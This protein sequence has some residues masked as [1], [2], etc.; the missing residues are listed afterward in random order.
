MASKPSRP[1][2][3][4]GDEARRHAAVDE[5]TFATALL[6]FRMRRAAE[7]VLGDGAQSSGRRSILKTLVA[8]GAQ[9]VPQM[10]R[11]RA[12]SRQHIQKL[13]NGLLDDDLVELLHNPAHKRSRLVAVT[14][15][16]RR[17]AAATARREER[18]LLEVSRGI[19]LAD[20]RTATRVLQTLEGAF[21]SQC[22]SENGSAGRVPSEGAD[23][24]RR[25]RRGSPPA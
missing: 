6:F 9:T 25:E 19:P 7:E 1:R 10:A 8:G 21:E 3:P 12:V 14:G 16:G 20:I 5:L 15:K 11:F 2:Q 23:P 22:R 4:A 24:G 13:V 18:I 17:V